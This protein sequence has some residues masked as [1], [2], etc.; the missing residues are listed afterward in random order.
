MLWV[1]YNA[2]VTSML[3]HA[4]DA[5]AAKPSLAVGLDALTA[6]QKVHAPFFVHDDLLCYESCCGQ[7]KPCLAVGGM[8]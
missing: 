7:A 8:S 5:A 1:V 6:G 3:C 2:H 4:R